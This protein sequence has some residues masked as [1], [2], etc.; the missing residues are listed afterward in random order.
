MNNEKGFYKQEL[1]GKVF[2]RFFWFMIIFG[3]IEILFFKRVVGWVIFI[4]G[5]IALISYYAKI[6]KWGPFKPQ[7]KISPK[8]A[9]SPLQLKITISQVLILLFSLL[10]AGTMIYY[11]WNW[12]NQVNDSMHKEC[13][14]CSVF[15]KDCPYTDEELLEEEYSNGPCGDM[16]SYELKFKFTLG[17]FVLG[18]LFF[19]LGIVM[20]IAN[21]FNVKWLRKAL[22]SE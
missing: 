10:I 13:K 4:G 3:I 6:N 21:C 5:V 14:M 12:Y 16:G 18:I 11:G 20:F 8:A 2:N 9:E 19:G 17:I 1:I 15:Q 7:P 22:F